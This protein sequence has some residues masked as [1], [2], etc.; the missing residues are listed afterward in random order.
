MRGEAVALVKPSLSQ[1]RKTPSIQGGDTARRRNQRALS[2]RQATHQA[3]LR[4]VDVAALNNGLAAEEAL[5]L[6]RLLRQQV[7]LHRMAAHQLRG[8]RSASQP[9]RAPLSHRAPEKQAGLRATD[10]QPTRN[11][12]HAQ[13][14]GASA[15]GANARALRTAHSAASQKP[16]T[17]ARAGRRTRADGTQR[18]SSAWPGAASQRAAGGLAVRRNPGR[19]SHLAR[20][21][22]LVAL[23]RRLA[24]L[25]LRLRRRG[26]RRRLG[27]SRRQPQRNGASAQRVAAA[28]RQAHGGNPPGQPRRLRGSGSAPRR[29]RGQRQRRHGQRKDHRALGTRDGSDSVPD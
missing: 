28:S 20:P 2:L 25:Q 4:V 29:R 26:A 16:L 10:G 8:G 15:S 1:C 19:R 22:H 21:G 24:R 17:L 18:W 11:S 27:S 6:G 3:V 7:P 23:R 12:C 14:P 5:A 9:G 13:L